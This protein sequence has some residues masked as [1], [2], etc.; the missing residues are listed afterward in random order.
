MKTKERPPPEIKTGVSARTPTPGY[1]KRD[2]Q[3]FSTNV[4]GAFLFAGYKI[5]NMIF[6]FNF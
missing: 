2:A 5:T 3:V 6:T 4:E 1:R